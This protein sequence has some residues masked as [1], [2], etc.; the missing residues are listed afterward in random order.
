MNP[1]AYDVAVG[2]SGASAD[3][4]VS[5]LYSAKPSLFTSSQSI[6]NPVGPGKATITWTASKAPT[7]DLSG[8]SKF[9]VAGRERRLAAMAA[10]APRDVS[11]SVAAELAAA[12]DQQTSFSVNGPIDFQIV[13][14]GE[15]G[16]VQHLQ[17]SVGVDI[18]VDASGKVSFSVSD[19]D[20]TGFDDPGTEAIVK[21]YVVPDLQARATEFLSGVSI[22]GFEITGVRLSAPIVLVSGGYIIMASSLA[23]G[24]GGNPMGHFPF[25]APAFMALSEAATNAV[26]VANVNKALHPIGKSGH[27]GSHGFDVHYSAELSFGHL[28]LSPVGAAVHLEVPLTGSVDAGFKFLWQNVDV[29][30]KANAAPTPSGEFLL[31]VSGSKLR[32]TVAK[33]QPFTILLTP[34]GGVISKVISAILDPVVQGVVLVLAPI[35]SSLIK[36]I[37]FDVTSIPPMPVSVGGVSVKAS[38]T[39]GRIAQ[40]GKG[41]AFEGDV[42]VSITASEALEA[43]NWK[44]AA[45]GERQE[46]VETSDASP[47]APPFTLPEILYKG[48]AV[49]QRAE[50]GLYFAGFSQRC[51]TGTIDSLSDT[52]MSAHGQFDADFHYQSHRIKGSGTFTAS[53]SWNSTTGK[54]DLAIET[55]GTWDEK[56][57]GSIGGAIEDGKPVISGTLDVGYA[58]GVHVSFK[59]IDPDASVQAFTIVHAPDEEILPTGFITR[60]AKG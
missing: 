16:K 26:I 40:F 13:A 4:I 50:G 57:T 54:W 39:N 22:P 11:A 45:E 2:L 30:Y 18:D 32:A 52:A 19:I 25:G 9:A 10:Q 31:G 41:L 38:L 27:K 29:S 51:G 23:T 21:K 44:E 33:L 53:V 48:A 14:N 8:S 17:A 42:D 1:N 56:W 24:G 36:G 35:A 46:G 34:S 28:S 37:S 5:R 43:A 12:L 58:V 15:K 55:K 60:S 59:R 20:I 7:L 47:I 3:E 49:G 6:P